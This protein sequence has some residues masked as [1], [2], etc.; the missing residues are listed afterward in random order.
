MAFAFL[1][2]THL[3]WT[4]ASGD[5]EHAADLAERAAALDDGDPWAYLALG[6]LAFT[7]RQTDEAVRYF[8][9]AGN[10]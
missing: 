6:Y 3:R 4:A 5:R 1:V 9:A 8:R 10:P 2:S 7:A